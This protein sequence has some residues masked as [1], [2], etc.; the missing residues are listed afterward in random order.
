MDDV[1]KVLDCAL[2]VNM[3]YK[4]LYGSSSYNVL[5]RNKTQNDLTRE[6]ENWSD[7]HKNVNLVHLNIGDMSIEEVGEYL[8]NKLIINKPNSILLLEDFDNKTSF[9][10]RMELKTL[11]KD[12]YLK[13]NRTRRVFNNLLFA[14][15]I[16]SDKEKALDYKEREFFAYERNI[17]ID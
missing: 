10:S 16:I 4:E 2:E 9:E 11:I 7:D 1:R 5:L 3:Y 12:H 17:F 14:V 6:I 15:A 13:E 8:H